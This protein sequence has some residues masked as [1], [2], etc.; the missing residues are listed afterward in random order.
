MS[1]Q[2]EDEDVCHARRA[3]ANL[4]RMGLLVFVDQVERETGVPAALILGRRRNKSVWEARRRL[5]LALRLYGLSLHEIG[6]L[7]GRDHTT[8]IHGLRPVGLKKAGL[9]PSTTREYLQS[10]LRIRVAV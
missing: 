3:A 10:T 6:D 1:A 7:L 5:Y 8:I 9:A 2:G 4:A